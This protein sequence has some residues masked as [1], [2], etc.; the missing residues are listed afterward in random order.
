MPEK[1][2]TKGIVLRETQTKEADKILTVLTAEHGRIALV[3]RGARRKNSKIAAASELLAFSELV[4]HEQH[5]W[6]L[7]DEASTLA[8]WENIRRDIALLALA[9]YFA[10]LTEAATGEGE[11]AEETLALLLNALYALDALGKPPEQVKAA[12]ELKL[13]AL[14]G[15]APLLTECAVCGAGAPE[16][17]LFDAR[18][19]VVVCRKCA[20]AAANG[21]LPLDGG[22]LAAMRHVLGAE[23]KRLLS[24]A[25]DGGPLSRF[26]RACETFTRIQLERDFRTL[27]FYRSLRLPGK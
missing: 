26:A 24:F 10:E 3:A 16:E 15:Y 8:L 27:D 2:V 11:R 20:G 6:F 23:R 19:G 1:I 18:E 13:L 9:S 25:L 21:L 14:A 4:V 7:L 22:S 17:P 5:G 12:F